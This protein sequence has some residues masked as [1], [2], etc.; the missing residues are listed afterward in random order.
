MSAVTC[1]GIVRI[2]PSQSERTA[3]VLG[4]ETVEYASRH[5]RSDGALIIEDTVDT[6]LI[7]EARRVF[8][9]AYSR[10]LDGGKHSDALRVGKRRLIVTINL[11]PPFDDPQLFA[12]PYLLPVLEAALD[13]GFVLGAF[14]IV[15]S[16]P[17]APA[18][19]RHAD[20]GFLFPRS[21]IDR[22]LP[23]SAITVGIPLLEMNEVHGTTAL[24]L[25]SH[26]D[27]SRVP[28]ENEEGIEPVVR[29]G[30]CILWDFRLS[31][32]GTPN[33]S[34]LP[35]PLLYLT[36]C[37]PW[38]LDHLNYG[39]R[40]LKQKPLLAREDFLSGLSEQHQHLLIRAQEGYAYPLHG[41]ETRPDSEE[42]E[43]PVSVT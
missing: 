41:L 21:G 10:Y 9:E 14:G 27:A 12:N 37:R 32:G 8:G 42:V 29:E 3:G 22:L 6:V 25:G 16:L 11:E 40:N 34:A 38:F 31:H 4:T 30:S 19:H 5:V 2:I 1:M 33:R 13:E 36:Y 7:G 18:Q 43:D 23:A 35:R 26:R 15:C 17:S 28:D 20:G 24:W 39:K